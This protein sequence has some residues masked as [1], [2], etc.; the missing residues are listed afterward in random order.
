L[1]VAAN[2]GTL[3]P[4]IR[5]VKTSVIQGDHA[6]GPQESTAYG[7]NF[8]K[9]YFHR[10]PFAKIPFFENLTTEATEEL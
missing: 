9:A 1:A 2:T 5:S 10:S 3:S 8:R 6:L 7:S 4:G